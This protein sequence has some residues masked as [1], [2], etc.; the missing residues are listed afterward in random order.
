MGND[1][2]VL[3]HVASSVDRSRF[4]LALRLRCLRAISLVACALLAVAP[5]GAASQ[6]STETD[7]V[8]Q[9][10]P[11]IGAQHARSPDA[12][13]ARE[14][15]QLEKDARRR[16]LLCAQWLKGHLGWY[17]RRAAPIDLAQCLKM[18]AS[19]TIR[20]RKGRTPLHS[21]AE[22]T[23]DPDV[24]SR[25][26]EAGADVMA[27]TDDRF[28]DTPLHLAA[29]YNLN[30]DVIARLI[31]LGADVNAKN[32]DRWQ[33][34]HIAARASRNPDIS[35]LLIERGADMTSTVDYGGVGSVREVSLWDLAKGNP[36]VHNSDWYRELEAQARQRQAAEEAK[37]LAA[38]ERQ[39]KERERLVEEVKRKQRERLAE[40][41]KRRRERE[42]LAEEAR[43]KQRKR[44]AEKAARIAKQRK[45][46]EPVLEEIGVV[47]SWR[48]RSRVIAALNDDRASSL[49]AYADTIPFLLAGI[50]KH[51]EAEE[52][53]AVRILRDVDRWRRAG[54][55]KA[56]ERLTTW[57]GVAALL[58]KNCLHEIADYVVVNVVF[59]KVGQFQS[60]VFWETA[61]TPVHVHPDVKR[62]LEHVPHGTLADMSAMGRIRN[63]P[64]ILEA[65]IKSA[66]EPFVTSCVD[67]FNAQ[68]E[69][70]KG[71]SLTS[72]QRDAVT[73][74]C[75]CF[76]DGASAKGYLADK[77]KFTDV[78]AELIDF[79]KMFSP[80]N[81]GIVSV[82]GRCAALHG[83]SL[84]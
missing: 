52:A 56:S 20:D 79:N 7:R 43:A 84:K 78:M 30:V 64:R 14:R 27:R 10:A 76:H 28:K 54:I 81:T 61:A 50:G 33:P 77:P 29:R 26:V 12:L 6:R 42:R 16:A 75:T 19:V 71:Q 2:G 35:A 23:K 57:I 46:C 47:G 24:V 41:E 13:S 38:L 11:H 72:V 80:T 69:L 8:W 15:R 62:A 63:I 60:I 58:R 34:L 37:R 44:L 51:A 70:R 68:S 3:V 25:L 36:A 83:Q 18:G 32:E 73:E 39:R 59:E 21:A 65:A 49:D 22:T 31:D 9:T 67:Y 74:M 45:S 48:K 1:G 17:F 53:F 82:L 4:A 5:T 55:E 66:G 40:Y